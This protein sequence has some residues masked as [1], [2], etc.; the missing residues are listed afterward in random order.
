MEIVV[1]HWKRWAICAV[2]V[3]AAMTWAMVRRSS[4]ELSQQVAAEE[5]RASEAASLERAILAYQAVPMASLPDLISPDAVAT[6]LQAARVD[7]DE[8]QSHTESDVLGVTNAVAALLY[9]R[10]AQADPE[11]Y[12]RWRLQA[13]YVFVDRN[14]LLVASGEGASYEAC[15]GHRPS[16]DQTLNEIFRD[17]WNYQINNAAL[18]NRPVAV[19]GA[20]LGQSVVFGTR[21]TV[22]GA[23]IN[24]RPKPR[25]DLGNDAW[26]V[27]PAAF[28]RWFTPAFNPDGSEQTLRAATY[29]IVV[30]YAD[31]S[32][33]PLVFHLTQ[34]STSKQW[35]VDWITIRAAR[36]DTAEMY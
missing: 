7:D 30:Q 9:H 8:G 23:K 15:F 25:G 12:I 32:R 10:Y 28:T 4:Q 35:L 26:N 21:S 3:A 24:R 13:G 11:V 17:F 22:P 20:S 18:H 14:K 16:D 27:R 1:K 19:A 2:A 5:L 29:G 34:H 31:G 6:V 33:R 36:A